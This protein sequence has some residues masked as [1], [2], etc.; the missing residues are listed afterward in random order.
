MSNKTYTLTDLKIRQQIEPTIEVETLS[1]PNTETN[2]ENAIRKDY[3][4]TTGAESKMYAFI[5]YVKINNVYTVSPLNIMEFKIG[6]K[7][8]MS[9]IYIRVTDTGNDIKSKYY[10]KNGSVLNV[11]IG[12]IG[13]E[14][15]YK[16][17]RMDFLITSVSESG[18]M[19]V[20]YKAGGSSIYSISGIV[21]IPELLYNNNV[22]RSGTS[23]DTLKCISEELGL[24]FAS[25]VD[26]TN[27]DS[28]DGI[29]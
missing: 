15:K 7:D 22:Y 6:I 25:N 19:F 5:P 14:K 23:F 9:T 11:Y 12:T 3:I 2:D 24:G 28:I 26:D 17:Y 16:P 21:N 13:D 18:N 8:F 10:P 20:N 4:S 29:V 1:M 27:D